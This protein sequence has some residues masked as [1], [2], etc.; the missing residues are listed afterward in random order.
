MSVTRL[1]TLFATLVCLVCA[2]RAAQRD[3]PTA[4]I[5]RLAWLAGCWEGMVGG[6]QYYEHWMKPAGGAMM[7]VSQTVARGKTEEY[8]FL[9]IRQEENGV[10]Y[11]AKPSG[12]AEAAFR[13]VEHDSDRAMFENPQHDFPQRIIY[14]LRSDGGLLA[15]I[16][17]R[18]NGTDKGFDHPLTRVRCD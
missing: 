7:G 15:R 16:E 10:F 2:P 14:R 13:L 8:E 17:G 6:S 11:V 3:G 1:L 12:Q 18:E 9:Q 4:S 5:D